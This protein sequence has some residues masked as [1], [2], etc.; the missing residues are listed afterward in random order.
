MH[1]NNINKC[2]SDLYIILGIDKNASEDEIKKA[3]KKMI[4]QYHPDKNKDKNAHEQFIKIQSAYEILINNKLRDDYD[5]LNKEKY[6]FSE[7]IEYFCKK[8]KKN[9]YQNIYNI[10]S[11]IYDNDKNNNFNFNL[12]DS[13]Y[14]NQY[15]NYINN[16][17]F[18]EAF[19]YLINR[20]IKRENSL[21][22]ID[23]IECDLI[24]R[25]NNNY[26]LIEVIRKSRENIKLYVPLRNEINVYYGEGEIDDGKVGD[27][28]LHTKTK[29]NKGFYCKNGDMFK[30]IEI[31]KNNENE[32]LMYYFHIDG[33]KIKINKDEIIDNKYIIFYGLGLPLSNVNNTRGDLVCEIK[34]I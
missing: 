4:L 19:N 21:N 1:D 22:I 17:K 12:H 5:K 34:Y 18:D 25:Y 3:Y 8:Y 6:N 20:Y 9:I 24:N 28:I 23:N 14:D 2:S 29:N 30:E 13:E 11:F 26:M 15:I 16:N 27:I 31:E 32:D 33:E 10:F 7:T